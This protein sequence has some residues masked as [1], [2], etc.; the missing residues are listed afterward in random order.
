MMTFEMF[1]ERVG[2]HTRANMLDDPSHYVL[3]V[4]T[5]WISMPFCCTQQRMGQFVTEQPDK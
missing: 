3:H 4:S 1:L 5:I 2:G